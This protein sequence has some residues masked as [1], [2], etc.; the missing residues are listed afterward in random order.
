MMLAYTSQRAMSVRSNEPMASDAR[1]GPSAA[2]HGS[3]PL[4][5]RPDPYGLEAWCERHIPTLSRP[6]LR[7]GR[8]GVLGPAF[9]LF[10]LFSFGRWWEWVHNDGPVGA[11]VVWTVAAGTALVLAKRRWFVAAFPLAWIAAQSYLH[12]FLQGGW[13]YFLVGTA[14]AVL[15]VTL[16]AVGIW[17]EQRQPK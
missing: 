12:L 10:A 16:F 6:F 1:Q 8:D 4:M 2:T 13:E 7:Y 9:A 3:A 5:A 15:A 11:A 17:T 14:S